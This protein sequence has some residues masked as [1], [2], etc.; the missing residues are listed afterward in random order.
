VGEQI[1]KTEAGEPGSGHLAERQGQRPPQGARLGK[2]RD[3][4]L[5]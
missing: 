4:R 3:H 1:D 5:S 2:G